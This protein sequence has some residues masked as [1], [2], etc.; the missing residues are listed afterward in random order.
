MY[1]QQLVL[2]EGRFVL[3]QLLLLVININLDLDTE[4]VHLPVPLGRTLL[5]VQMACSF[6]PSHRM[7]KNEDEDED[8]SRN[9]G[10]FQSIVK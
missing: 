10:H 1:Q 5:L 9:T 6:I 2:E 7:R 3:D 4:M 8:T